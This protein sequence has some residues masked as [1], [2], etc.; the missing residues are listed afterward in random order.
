MDITIT[1]ELASLSFHAMVVMGIILSALFLFT[2]EDLPLAS[3][4]LF[5][6]VTLVLFF[7]VFPY[8]TE[9]RT[10]AA[11]D[12]FSGFGHEA[13]IAV[14]ALM[15]AGQGLVR[16]GALEPIGRQLARYWASYPRLSMIATLFVGAVLSAFV[17]NTPIV[18]LL[19]PILISVSLRTGTTAAHTLM[20]MGFAT[21]IGGTTTTIG[22]S[23]NLLVVFVAIDLGLE[24]FGMFDFAL[25]AIIAGTVGLLYLWLIAPSLFLSGSQC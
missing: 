21:L 16:T 25:P 19:L 22:T 24:Q 4:S 3:S 2:R 17:N 14:S 6:L 12:F 7:E 18:I 8:T 5:I 23:T 1:A 9:G 11:R 20:P 10:L 13:L 15:I